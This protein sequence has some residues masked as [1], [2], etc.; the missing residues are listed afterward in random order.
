MIF[1][2]EIFLFQLQLVFSKG[3]TKFAFSQYNSSTVTSPQQLLASSLP[4]QPSQLL[5]QHQLQQQRLKSLSNQT[6]TTVQS[7]MSSILKPQLINSLLSNNFRLNNS[8]NIMHRTKINNISKNNNINIS[9]K[10]TISHPFPVNFLKA[11]AKIPQNVASKPFS[12][13]SALAQFNANSKQNQSINVIS[14]EKVDPIKVPH[15]L[16]INDLLKMSKNS[17]QPKPQVVSLEQKMKQQIQLQQKQQ[18]FQQQLQSSQWVLNNTQQQQKILLQP[19][20]NDNQFRLVLHQ[21]QPQLY[22]HNSQQSFQHNSQQP[23]ITVPVQSFMQMI[24]KGQ[25]NISNLFNNNGSTS[26]NN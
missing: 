20:R 24:N 8:N 26:N 10:N 23:Q 17:L 16:K 19:Q 9:S 1:Q 22:Q 5:L 4:K 11:P 7:Q 2:I 13:N 6:P 12:I 3:N 18:Q 15:S 25:I 14:H 21:R